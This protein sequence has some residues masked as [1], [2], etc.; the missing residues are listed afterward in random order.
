MRRPTGLRSIGAGGIET[1]ISLPKILRPPTWADYKDPVCILKLA[2]CGHPDAGGYWERHCREHLASVGF[3]SVPDWRSTYW[4]IELK[5]LLTVY[6]DGFKMAGPSANFTEAWGLMRQ[7]FKTDEPHA[8]TI[9]LGC[10][11]LVRDTR[12]G[13]VGQAY[14]IGITCVPSL[15]NV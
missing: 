4:H 13:C 15:N 8:V 1:W 12:G 11:H 5:L 9:C 14:R 7:K 10:E 2:L 6:V 3:V